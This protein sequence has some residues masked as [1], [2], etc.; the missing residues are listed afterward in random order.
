MSWVGIWTVM[1]VRDDV[2]QPHRARFAGLLDAHADD[3]EVRV[4]LQRWRSKPELVKGLR[5]TNPGQTPAYLV[6][7]EPSTSF[8]HLS[9][10]HPIFFADPDWVY[11]ML[12]G[13]A[14][15]GVEKYFVVTDRL[16]PTAALFHGLGPARAAALP[17][18]FGSFLLNAAET[19]EA[20]PA[21]VQAFTLDAA[22]REAAVIRMR[23]WATMGDDLDAE[24]LLR[25]FPRVWEEA[26]QNGL[27]LCGY[28]ET[29]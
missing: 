12:A 17:G 10:G 1:Q 26:V 4:A 13:L 9:S 7:D 2:L 23:D 6:L 24:A 16:N 19:R 22:E 18:Y 11:T 28:T 5:P 20:L 21:V 27:G 15:P 3:P 14:E 29:T 8:H 25:D